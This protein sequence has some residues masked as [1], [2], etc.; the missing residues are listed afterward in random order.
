MSLT[1]RRTIQLASASFGALAVQGFRQALA[2]GETETH[3][4][5]TFGELALPPDFKHF[6]YVNPD[7]PKGGV[8]IGTAQYTIG[9]QNGETFDTFNIYNFKGDG[10]I[11]MDN[12]FDALMAAS[13]DEPDSI[14]GLVAKAVRVSADKL[15][16]RF[17]LR[18]EARFHDGSRLTAADVAFSLM[19][20]KEKGHPMFKVTLD[21]LA[22][23]EAE[24][25]DVC[26]V[27]FTPQRGRDMHLIVASLPI[28]SRAWYTAHEFDAVSL[29]PPLG[30]GAYKVSKFEQG[31]FNEFERVKDYWAANLPVNVGLNN[32]DRI[33]FE[34][35]RE[36]QIAFE[37][38]KAGKINYHLENTARFWANSYDFPAVKEGRVI[39]EEL[40]DGSPKP[41][42]GWVFNMRRPQFA[43]RRIR[44]AINYC[45]DFEWT[46]KNIMFNA[47]TR[48]RSYFQGEDMEARGLAGP[49]ELALLEPFR[50][51]LP[52]EVFGEAWTP[53]VSDG[54][55]SDRNALRKADELLR[56]AG[57][58]RDGGKLLL[59]NGG[60]FA[61]EFLDY[62]IGLQP[63]TGPF[64]ANLKKL[65]IDATS[66]IVDSVQFKRR[67]DAFDFD[68]MTFGLSGVSTPGIGLLSVFSSKEARREGS[69]NVGGIADTVVDALLEKVMQADTREALNVACRALDRVL[70]AGIYWV[71][72]WVLEK[73]R[74][75][76]WD[77]FSRPDRQPKFESGAPGPAGSPGGPG[78]WW[79]DAEKATKIGW[80]G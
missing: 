33:R 29:E 54:S 64:I 51:R 28:F 35:Y 30:S 73:K 34:Y 70:R 16:Y 72:M 61:I 71:P 57:C 59:P 6:A 65:G 9:N 41:T 66:R 4:L 5:S 18:S 38:F 12:V 19:L 46:S 13:S 24:S 47:Y 75:A 74:I 68:I 76:H 17:L 1:R 60:P 21:T 36:R 48:L 8:L 52:A 44:E 11:G 7:A 31:R 58:K 78:T 50:A 63:H 15:T 27:R 43:D 25:D 79:F 69:Q 55:G 45:F 53:P 49:D 20:M 2:E 32:L 14:Y 22:S 56:A 39:R 42:Q 80:R 3:G 67:R 10:A 40:P 37:D 62:E 26:A 77:V 23:A